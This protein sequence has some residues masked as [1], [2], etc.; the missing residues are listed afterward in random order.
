[1]PSTIQV[2][3]TERGRHLVAVAP[4]EFAALLEGHLDAAEID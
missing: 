2:A 3:R 4:A 1:M